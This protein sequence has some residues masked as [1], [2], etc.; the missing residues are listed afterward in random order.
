MLS[1]YAGYKNWNNF[2]AENEVA[3]VDMPKKGKR[4]W[5]LLLVFGTFLLSSAYFLI[6]RTTTFSFCFMDQDRNT[7]IIDIP[8]NITILNDKQSP[9][10]I[11]SDSLGCFNW[12]TKDNFIHFIITSPYHK[13]DTI[14]RT[15]SSLSN[16]EQ[17]KV[18]T[19]DYALMLHYYAN[20]KVENWKKRRTEL[21]R[22]IANDAIIFQVLPSG[23]GIEI[24]T[25]NE[26][27]DKIT[28]P[29]KSLK[30][31]EIIE[32]KRL[33]EQIVKLKFRIKS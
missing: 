4:K 14:F 20:G 8:I 9:F 23:L 28:T 12:T 2:K 16:K 30:G 33:N 25:K 13:S 19:D 6:P 10:Y 5:I 11:K 31:I 27:I 21:V 29:T 15:T 1:E 7:T 24:Y 26:F 3:K 17:I 22:M 18:H 32:S